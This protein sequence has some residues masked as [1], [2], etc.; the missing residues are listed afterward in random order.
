[1]AQCFEKSPVF[2]ILWSSWA[3]RVLLGQRGSSGPASQGAQVLAN[4]GWSPHLCWVSSPLLAQLV[5]WRRPSTSEPVS[6]PLSSSPRTQDKSQCFLFLS[7][8]AKEICALLYSL[9]IEIKWIFL[10]RM[11]WALIIMHNNDPHDTSS[12]HLDGCQGCSLTYSSSEE[13]KGPN[14]PQPPSV[15]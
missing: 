7:R 15:G 2:H 9:L 10:G 5:A 11:A 12:F 14:Y 13:R 3:A 8:V 4:L 6:A 1:M